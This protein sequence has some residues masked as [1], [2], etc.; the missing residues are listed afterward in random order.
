M[1]R[2][3]G[4][5]HEELVFFDME[6]DNRDEL[7]SKLSDELYKKGYVKETFKAAVIARE[8]VF[9]TGL[10]TAGVKVAIP[11]TDAEHVNKATIVFANL[12]KPVIFK[13]MGLGEADIHA[14]LIIMMAINNPSEQVDTLSKLMNIFSNKKLLLQLKATSK[15]EE[16][17]E[18]LEKQIG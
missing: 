4:L 9:P 11:H 12:K 8:K 3:N 6:A 7:L 13:E 10:P 5:L 1:E 17:L 15:R 18:L 14:E 16:V 2:A